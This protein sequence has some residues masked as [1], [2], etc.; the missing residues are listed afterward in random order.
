MSVKR[1]Q[2]EIDA[3]EFREWQEF[4]RYEPFGQG[5][6]QSVQICYWVYRMLRGKG[7]TDLEVEDFLP[8]KPPE[9]ERQPDTGKIMGFFY[10]IGARLKAKKGA[11]G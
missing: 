7:A 2:R 3:R 6:K 8:V 1:C 10:A 5:W 11:G 4:Y 9:D